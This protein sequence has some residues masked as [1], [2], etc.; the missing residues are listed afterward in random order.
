[1][2]RFWAH[3]STKAKEQ[4]QPHDYYFNYGSQQPKL[5][6]TALPGRIARLRAVPRQLISRVARLIWRVVSQEVAEDA[7]RPKG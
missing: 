1:M 2:H 5:K 6:P 7:G 3:H 4:R